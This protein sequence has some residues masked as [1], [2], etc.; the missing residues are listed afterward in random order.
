MQDKEWLSPGW[1]LPSPYGAE[2]ELLLPLKITHFHAYPSALQDTSL[3]PEVKVRAET[4]F[5]P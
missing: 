5:L 1:I 2:R 3:V 4:A